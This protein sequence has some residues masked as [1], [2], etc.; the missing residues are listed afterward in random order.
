M[1]KLITLLAVL[2]FAVNVFGAISKQVPKEIELTNHS[3]FFSVN[4]NLEL[5]KNQSL[6]ENKVSKQKAL[7]GVKKINGGKSRL[8]ALL[9]CIFFGVLGLH[10]F[11]LGY[12]GWGLIYLFTG[13]IF[14]IGWIIDIIRLILG[15]LKPK[16]GSYE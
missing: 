15:G 16:D 3:T 8:V 4:E 6:K 9:L 13:G 2:A 7:S 10:R 12:W 11:Y 5:Q 14:G 1:K